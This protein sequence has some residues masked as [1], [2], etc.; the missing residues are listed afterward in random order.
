MAH[1]RVDDE[2]VR[3]SAT[4]TVLS[5]AALLDA[6]W[7]G[8][9]GNA[10]LRRFLET[11]IKEIRLFSRDEKKHDLAWAESRDESSSGRQRWTG[12]GARAAVAA[13]SL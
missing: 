13:P 9:F 12:P 7:T 11:Q 1:G 10:V 5:G 3:P 2:R 8:T 6:D 4:I